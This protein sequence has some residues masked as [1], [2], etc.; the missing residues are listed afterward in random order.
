[1]NSDDGVCS[2]DVKVNMKV[3]IISNLMISIKIIFIWIDIIRLI[4]IIIIIKFKKQN[5]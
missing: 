2:I 3:Y 1:M 4:T 5:K